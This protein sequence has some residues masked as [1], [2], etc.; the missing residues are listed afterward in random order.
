M[1]MRRTDATVSSSISCM[2]CARS[3]ASGFGWSRWQAVISSLRAVSR[4]PSSSCSS[5]AMRR[6]SSSRASTMLAE[7]SRKVRR[8]R[9]RSLFS[10]ERWVTS[11]MTICTKLRS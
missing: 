6:R 7:S 1:A 11:L 5:R 3:P 4:W 2:S 9:S 8:E 10:R